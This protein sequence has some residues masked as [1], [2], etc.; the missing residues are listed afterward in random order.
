MPGGG[1]VVIDVDGERVRGGITAR[2]AHRL[3][4]EIT[5]PFTGFR[6]ESGHVML[7]ARSVIRFVDADGSLTPRG[8]ERVERLL[9]SLHEACRRVANDLPAI[10]H[11]LGRAQQAGRFPDS[12]VFERLTQA[13]ERRWG[14]RTV[15]PALARILEASGL[16]LWL[17]PAELGR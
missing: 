13:L 3:E 2:E 15:D 6:C 1:E 4:V 17:P 16:A 11:E 8:V 12:D 10:L 14:V 9:R 5:E 7:L